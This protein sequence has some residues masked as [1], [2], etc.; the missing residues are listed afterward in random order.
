M[1]PVLALARATT[2]DSGAMG[3]QVLVVEDDAAIR[4]LL[5]DVLTDEGYIVREAGDGERALSIL[6]EWHPD[7]VILD[8]GLPI[9]DGVEFR[10]RQ[11]TLGLAAEVPVIVLSARH[12]VPEAELAAAEVVRKPFDLDDLLETVARVVGAQSSPDR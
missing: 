8:L 4:D 10:R 9:V 1:P 5:R 3:A 12:E 6:E 2:H 11:A 7:L